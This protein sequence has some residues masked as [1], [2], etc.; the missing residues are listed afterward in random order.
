FSL[1]LSGILGPTIMGGLLCAALLVARAPRGGLAPV[2]A[3]FGLLNWLLF[4]GLFAWCSYFKSELYAVSLIFVLLALPVIAGYLRNEGGRERYVMLVLLPVLVFL[5]AS[6]KISTGAVLGVGVAAA[7]CFAGR[8]SLR[9]IAVAVFLGGVPIFLDYGLG[10]LNNLA[11]WG[12]TY[13]LQEKSFFALFNYARNFPIQVLVHVGFVVILS[14]QFL[15][16][17]PTDRRERD[18]G[19]ALLAMMWAAIC[20]SSILN[21]ETTAPWYFLNP[22]MW[23]GLVLMAHLSLASNIALRLSPKKQS[24]L[25]VVFFALMNVFNFELAKIGLFSVDRAWN[26]LEAGVPD[27]PGSLGTRLFSQTELGHAFHT[28]KQSEQKIDGVHVAADNP[29][30]WTLYEK[31]WP[32]SYIFPATLGI[33]MLMGRPPRS[34]DC[35]ETTSYG[36]AQYPPE[37]SSARPLTDS[38]L[39][40]AAQARGMATIAVLRADGV[41][42]ILPGKAE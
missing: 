26:A 11:G 1:A 30:F 32:S 28:M 33:P 12:A 24:I 20:A 39:V 15:R 29:R 34:P 36:M 19:L 35:E 7:I 17:L 3:T 6:S 23:I 38:D 4:F 31:C 22:S 37:K 42:D 40:V 18:I 25:M 16:H 13:N 9:A 14:L 5:A 41:L 10:R 2:P 21:V 27:G 8:F